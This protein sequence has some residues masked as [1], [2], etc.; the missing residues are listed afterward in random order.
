MKQQKRQYSL[1]TAIAMLLG[2]VIGSGIFFK[3]DDMLRYTG[4]NV[5]I[6]VLIFC[7]AAFTIVFGSLCLSKLAALTDKPG[8]IVTYANEF[9][10]KRFAIAFGWFQTFIYF[11]TL[12][13]L[14]SWVVGV[15]TGLLFGLD[16]SFN[17]QLVIGFIWFLICFGYNIASAKV[18]GKFQEI[19]VIIKLIPL[20]IIGIAGFVFGDPISVVMHPT[21]EAIA[22]TTTLGWIAAIGPVAFSFDGWII[23]MAIS[24]E[25]KDAKKNMPRALVIAPIFVLAVYLLYFLGTCGYLGTEKV[26]ALG[27]SSVTFIADRLL[28]PTFA[29]FITAFVTISVMGAV[30]GAVLGFIR[31]PYSLA[32]RNGLPGSNRLKKLTERSGMPVNSAKLAIVICIVWWMIHFLQN[33]YALLINGDI[34]E[35]AVSMSYVLYIP[36]YFQLFRLWRAGVVKGIAY[37]IVFPVLATIGSLFVVIAGLSNPQ[38]ILFITVGLIVIVAGFVYGGKASDTVENYE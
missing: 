25:V 11:P 38:F 1:F 17:Q 5:G 16:L 21:P 2:I 27:D 8:G 28:G 6:A 26:M 18:G 31:M 34:S 19:T 12:T 13:V 24:H 37:G 14:I 35:I 36:V 20:F 23:S 32:L 9:V 10:G 4:G 7:I 33:K 22:A 3:A 30:N 15:Y 29:G